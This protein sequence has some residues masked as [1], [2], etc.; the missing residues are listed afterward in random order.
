MATRRLRECAAALERHLQPS[1]FKA[2]CDPSRLALLSR[3]ATCGGSLSVSEASDCCGV[4]VSGTSRH[5]KMLEQAG[6]AR[7]QRQ[8]REVRYELNATALVAALRGLANAIEACCDQD[9]CCGVDPREET[10]DAGA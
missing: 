3:L 7:A 2:L 6:V 10:D 5:L 8:G 4:H 9:G 1:L